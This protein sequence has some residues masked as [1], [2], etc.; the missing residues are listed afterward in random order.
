M[1]M[2]RTH[3][4]TLDTGCVSPRLPDCLVSPP[5]LRYQQPHRRRCAALSYRAAQ[6]KDCGYFKHWE[7]DCRLRAVQDDVRQDPITS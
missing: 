6:L 7:S 1:L 3:G 2:S 4:I 5:L